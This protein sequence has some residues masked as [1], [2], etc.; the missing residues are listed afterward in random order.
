MRL[1]LHGTLDEISRAR[2]ELLIVRLL[3]NGS[4]RALELANVDV[5][6]DPTGRT[7]HLYADLREERTR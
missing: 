6:T 3:P 7:A 1:C 5:G 2:D 4:V